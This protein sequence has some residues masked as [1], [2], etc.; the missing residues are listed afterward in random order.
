M[1]RESARRAFVF[2]EDKLLIYKEKGLF[3]I[4]FLSKLDAVECSITDKIHQFELQDQYL[5]TAFEIKTLPK[6]LE[7][8]QYQLVTVRESYDY[9]PL[10]AYQAAG[11]GYQLLFWDKNTQFCPCC[12]AKTERKNE[13]MKQ[14][15]NCLKEQYPPIQTA[16]LALIIKDDQILLAHAHNFKKEFYSLIAGF[17]EAGETLE[18]C[19]KREV[20]E[21][22]GLSIKNIRYFGNQPWPYPSGLMVGFIADWASGE[23]IIQEEELRSADFYPINQL[24]A[25]PQKLSLAR[26]MIDWW[27]ES[28]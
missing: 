3:T 4:P 14:C 2:Y 22:T 25:L 7:P 8:N 21:E 23:V 12:G 18:E 9:L 24:P 6:N 20:L 27:I 17:L 11:K 5:C 28:Q 16:I 26:K 19:V 13:I 1:E 10:W 15:P